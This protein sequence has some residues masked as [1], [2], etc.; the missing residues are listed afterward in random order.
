MTKLGIIGAGN[1]SETHARAARE[2]NGIEIAAI[3]GSNR[4]KATRLAQFYGGAVYENFETFLEHKPLDLVII[5][6]PSGLHAE[7]GIAAARRGL[8]VLVEKPIDI[9]TARADALIKECARAG[10]KLGICFQ[11]RVAPDVARLKQLVEAGS[12][13]RPI[14]V[15]A[16]VKWYRPPEYY[17]D[18]RWR[19]T[20]DLDGGG[21]LINQGI[22]TVDLLLWLMGNV[23]R[24][25][26][27]AIAALH[28]IEVEDTV[29]ATL[30]FANGAI[31]TLEAATSVYPGYPRRIELTGSEGTIILEDSQIVAADLRNPRSDFVSR[32]D[33]V[34]ENS[35]KTRSNSPVVSDV[36][37]HKRILEDFL[38]AI[39]T[40]G[41]PMCD[42][43]EGRRSVELVQAIYESSRT[44]EA[45]T[46]KS[47]R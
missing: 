43:H 40:D 2:I 18:S 27:K 28:D 25:N 35:D 22:H 23:M 30:E 33:G 17:R 16:R 38:K 20:F 34:K 26:A 47:D 42:G 37:G 36:S 14:L 45:V 19:G 41:K 12:L 10:V 4:D 8:H 31:G 44:G 3:Y 9:T 46:I 21:A 15:S 11:D 39:A 32:S 1:I 29:V 5:G 6:S 13:G 7:Q 24:V